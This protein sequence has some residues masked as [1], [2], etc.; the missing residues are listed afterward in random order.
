MPAM[1][2]TPCSPT[3]AARYP[4]NMSTPPAEPLQEALPGTAYLGWQENGN[5]YHPLP[6][7]EKR[8]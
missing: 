4:R 1:A 7:A 2:F 6:C 3:T 5:G 8:P